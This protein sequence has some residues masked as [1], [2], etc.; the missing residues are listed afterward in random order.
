MKRAL[1]VAAVVLA[2]GAAGFCV[3]L[4]L[5]GHALEGL[6]GVGS[7]SLL[8]A[9][10]RRRSSDGELS[11]SSPTPLPVGAYYSVKDG[12]HFRVAKL[13]AHS[14]GICHVRLYRQTFA[15]RPVRID[16][17]QLTL[18]ALDDAD[19]FGIGHVPLRDAGFLAWKPV[20]VARGRVTPEELEGYALW[21]NQAKGS[22]F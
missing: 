10:A 9:L 3:L 8:L 18:G 2:I 20:F 6:G 11:E 13:L 14:G 19:G 17:S 21:R 16:T 4:L 7:L 1:F 12:A 5:Q 15:T 22:T